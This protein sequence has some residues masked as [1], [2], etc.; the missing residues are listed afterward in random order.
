MMYINDENESGVSVN[1]FELFWCRINWI[2]ISIFL[3]IF[4][5]FVLDIVNWL[6]KDKV[7]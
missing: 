1:Y 7:W 4:V 5:K 3:V 6:V 2:K